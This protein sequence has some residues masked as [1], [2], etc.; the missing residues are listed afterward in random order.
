[1]PFDMTNACSA[2]DDESRVCTNGFVQRP[3]C[4]GTKCHACGSW[5]ADNPEFMPYCMKDD[6][7]D[8]FVV[9]ERHAFKSKSLNS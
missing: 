8:H 6:L 5:S 1:M 7:P 4:R 2:Y 3:A 9:M